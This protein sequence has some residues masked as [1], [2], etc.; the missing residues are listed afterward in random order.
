MSDAALP[1]E[2]L[3]K[4][5]IVAEQFDD[6]EQQSLSAE[7]GMWIF[8]GTEI[9]F[10]SG[11]FLGFTIYR[12]LYPGAFLTAA[13]ETLVSI[14]TT[15]T[16]VLLTSSVTVALAVKAAEQKRLRVLTWMIGLTILLGLAFMA[17]KGYEYREDWHEHLIPGAHDFPLSPQ[18]TQIFWSF[19]W[20][21][22]GIHAVHVT[23]GL[24][25]WSA[26]LVL[27]RIGRID[28]TRSSAVSVAGLYWHFVD[29]VWIFL[30][31]LLYLGGRSG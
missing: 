5:S 16:A 13:R 6:R 19:Y 1:E 23:I 27:F 11:L 9:L 15:N 25:I 21:M 30:W 10:F 31:P 7:L 20:I 29:I 3:G 24:G 22:T 2:A 26:L 18:Q 4:G 12:H 14:G 28:P 17:L 8:L